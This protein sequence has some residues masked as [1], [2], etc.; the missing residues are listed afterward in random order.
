MLSFH[1]MTV[2]E[3][4]KLLKREVEASEKDCAHS[5][6]RIGRGERILKIIG[7]GCAVDFMA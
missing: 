7:F 4:T 3:I 5:N 1:I 2:P 6:N